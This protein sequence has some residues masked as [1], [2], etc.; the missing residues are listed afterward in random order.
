MEQ[1]REGEAPAELAPH[2]FDRSLTLPI[3]QVWA[4]AEQRSFLFKNHRAT[5]SQRRIL[6]NLCIHG[7]MLLDPSIPIR[8]GALETRSV[9]GS[10]C[11]LHSA[12]R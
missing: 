12:E 3:N 7:T 2:W 5:M 4:F 9:H 6:S 8:T 11:L 1:Q 10:Y